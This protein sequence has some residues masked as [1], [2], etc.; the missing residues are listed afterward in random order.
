LSRPF[1]EHA[2][3][4]RELAQPKRYSENMAWLMDEEIRRIILEAESKA[5]NVLSENR[6]TL[7]RLTEAL[8]KEE[9]LD[10]A[11]IEKIIKGSENTET[12]AGEKKPEAKA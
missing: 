7:D 2:F 3:L 12:Q 8:I 11:E 9:T 4:G 10:R 1:C 6:A 5:E